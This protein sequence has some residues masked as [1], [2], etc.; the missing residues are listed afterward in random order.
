MSSV[1][2]LEPLCAKYGMEIVDL[3]KN[4]YSTDKENVINKALG[5]LVENGFYAMYVF[6]LSCKCKPKTYAQE[7]FD[8]LQNLLLDKDL[9]LIST[10]KKGVNGLKDIREITKNLPK[11]ILARKVTEQTL[12]FARYHCKAETQERG[13]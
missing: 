6:L 2:N 10:K 11:L 8:V 9:H 13:C 5:V 3:H 7:V 1:I 12:T 4:E